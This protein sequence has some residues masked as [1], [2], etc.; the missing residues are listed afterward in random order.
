[1]ALQLRSIWNAFSRKR[2][3]EEDSSRTALARVLTVFDL[4][5]LGAGSTLGL[6]VYVL[7]GSVASNQAGPAVTLSFLI[8]AVASG[9]AAVCYAE[10]AARVPKAGSAY[11]Y[12]YVSVGELV[13]FV[14][15]W[16]L[17]LEYIIGTASVARGLSS[18]IDSLVNHT[19]E[20]TLREVMPIDVSFLSP[21]PDFLS[22]GI[23]L[24]LTALLA[25]G[26]KEST[27]VNNVFTV[28][29]LA[30][31]MVVI[32]GGGIKSNPNNWKIPKQD[33]PQGK[34]SGGYMPYGFSGV[35]AGAAKCFYGF[36]G[37]DC[38]ATTGEEAKNPQRSIPLAILLSLI[39]IF[40]AYFGTST[41]LTMM[42]PY[43]DQDENAPFP[44]AFD[45]IGW[46][47]VKWIV[48]IGA[49]FA[50]TTSLMGSI[51]PLPRI[52]YAMANDGLVF[53]G[54]SKVHPKTQTPLIATILSGSLAG[55]MALIFDL[56]QLINM[57]SIG[58]LLAYSIV[59]ICILILRY[60]T[61]EESEPS[62]SHGV[63]FSSPRET[64]SSLFNL[65][66]I[67]NTHPTSSLIVD[68]SVVV[69]C[70]MGIAFDAILTFADM[71]GIWEITLVTILGVSLLV[72]LAII[73]RQPTSNMD[74]F[75]KVPL[76]PLVPGLSILINIY[77]M[78]MLDVF[79]WIRFG[80]WL[81]IGFCIYFFYGVKN[82][83]A[84]TGEPTV[85]QEE[86]E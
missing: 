18:Y 71:T 58:T 84:N 86:K 43:F 81:L 59:A 50:L 23:I 21:Y 52:F 20:N 73:A 13:A 54:L 14:I 68:C 47:A 17:I 70:L 48:T 78:L 29:N 74:L 77:L 33:V 5:A 64:F 22:V 28:L 8:A 53:K 10:F 60:K 37:F 12:S 7:A 83:T 32:I 30:T 62:D 1:M 38:V 49:I 63:F 15:G 75:F 24:L 40:L 65:K 66:G 4:T 56:Q 42:L 35:M 31:I 55:I 85:L 25:F 3:M 82:S 36:V 9:F 57:L 34:G 44:Y 41:V 46:T 2:F 79:T 76:V 67:K 51:F 69:F 11:V 6:G 45:K 16:N 19:M 72:S 26:V 80:V 27:A 39:I 61:N